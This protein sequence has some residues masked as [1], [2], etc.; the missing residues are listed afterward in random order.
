[1]MNTGEVAS[2]GPV[3]IAAGGGGGGG[4]F[5]RDDVTTTDICRDEVSMS[6]TRPV[7]GAVRCS[8]V[9]PGDV[10][11]VYMSYLSKLKLRLH[12]MHSRDLIL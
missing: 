12:R 10:H 1:M 3:W 2:T 11:E 7:C 9:E 8:A 6:V 5:W 4:V